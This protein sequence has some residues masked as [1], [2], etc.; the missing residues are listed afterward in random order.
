[1]TIKR[2]R[3]V[4]ESLNLKGAPYIWGAKGE[5]MLNPAFLT[6]LR[7]KVGQEPPQRIASPGA[8]ALDCS[9]AVGMALARAGGGSSRLWMWNTDA[10]WNNLPPVEVPSPGDVALYG[11][12][13]ID[14]V[15][16]IEMVITS[17]D[18]VI[19]VAGSSGGDQTT[20]TLQVAERQHAH[21][22]VKPSHLFR[23]DFRGFRSIVPLLG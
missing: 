2:S 16:H 7:T 6:W 9:G 8:F 17:V 5:Q 19:V 10:Y 18:G 20:T 12:K 4:A 22:K 21:Y 1:M 3:L 14:D 15:S 11:G 13:A 23:P